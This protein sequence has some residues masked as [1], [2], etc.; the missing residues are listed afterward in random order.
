MGT[1]HKKK[2]EVKTCTNGD[3]VSNQ[4]NQINEKRYT[5]EQRTPD[6]KRLE[7]RDE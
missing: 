3:E 2:A 7:L 1:L 6:K 4:K 5:H